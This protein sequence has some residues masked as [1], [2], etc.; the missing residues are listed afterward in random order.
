MITPFV[1]QLFCEEHLDGVEVIG[2]EIKA[3]CPACGK[4]KKHWGISLTSGRFR[5]WKCDWKGNFY[6][7]HKYVKGYYP[8]ADKLEESYTSELSLES[9][10]EIF[11]TKEDSQDR[12]IPDWTIDTCEID[13]IGRIP[14]KAREYLASRNISV[15]LAKDLDFRVAVGG[16]YQN[17]I[18]MPVVENEVVLNFVARLCGG[19]GK[20]YDG[21]H[22][23]EPYV[24]K[25]KLLWGFDRVK[26]NSEIVLV[27]GIFDAIPLLDLNAIAMLG[28]TLSDVQAEKLMGKAKSLVILL[29][30]E[31]LSSAKKVAEKLI[32]MIPIKIGLMKFGDPGENPEEARRAIKE[33]V[34]YYS[35]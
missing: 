25:S 12:E 1:I 16:R 28:K 3:N 30:A 19:E 6:T 20:R 2:D 10:N 26:Y 18:I 17:R 15:E 23:D 13:T 7:L 24:N 21:P 11:S 35:L 31:F 8:N 9:L 32:G 27:E 29:D 33:A 22:R 5:C 34:D 14:K 4:G